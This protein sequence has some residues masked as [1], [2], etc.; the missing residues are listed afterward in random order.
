MN[1]EYIIKVKFEFVFDY[2]A[3]ATLGLSLLY[4]VHYLH[5]EL[6]WTINRVEPTTPGSGICKSSH[7]VTVI[8]V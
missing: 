2:D 3:S 7:T 8:H 4:S 5:V 6:I 1:F